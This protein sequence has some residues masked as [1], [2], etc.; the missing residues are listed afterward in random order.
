MSCSIVGNFILSI[1]YVVAYSFCIQ[2]TINRPNPGA[3]HKTNRTEHDVF[4]PAFLII[5]T[6]R[7]LNSK[8]DVLPLP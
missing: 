4:I 6:R 3:F 8:S 7:L 1:G 5:I 2:R